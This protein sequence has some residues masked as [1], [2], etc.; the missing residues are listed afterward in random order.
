MLQPRSEGWFNSGTPVILTSGMQRFTIF[1]IGWMAVLRSRIAGL[2][3]PPPRGIRPA[4]TGGFL[5]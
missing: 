5:R 3:V 1:V 2:G 4:G